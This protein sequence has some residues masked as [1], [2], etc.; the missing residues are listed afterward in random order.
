MH[1]VERQVGCQQRMSK[2]AEHR[3][4]QFGKL[5]TRAT[6]WQTC[7]REKRAKQCKKRCTKAGREP[8]SPGKL[9]AE[10]TAA[11]RFLETTFEVMPVHVVACKQV[12]AHGIAVLALVSAQ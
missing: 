12:C 9:T 1:V 6:Q 2:L 11:A 4:L 8:S 5:G 10:G 7:A 3:V